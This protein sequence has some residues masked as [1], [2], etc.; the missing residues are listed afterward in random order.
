MIYLAKEFGY[1]VSG[2]DYSHHM[3]LAPENLLL[4]DVPDAELFHCDFFRF[5]PP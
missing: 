3:P 2:L 4:N 5:V 1:R